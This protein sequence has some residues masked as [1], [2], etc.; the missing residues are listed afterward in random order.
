MHDPISRRL[1]TSLGTGLVVGSATSSAS[2]DDKPVLP[3][4]SSSHRGVV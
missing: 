3:R 2:A 1:F 4:G